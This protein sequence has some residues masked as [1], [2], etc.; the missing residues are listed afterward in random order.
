MRAQA[1]AVATLV[2]DQ[3]PFNV[4]FSLATTRAYLSHRASVMATSRK[5]LVAALLALAEGRTHPGICTGVAGAG[6]SRARLAFMFSGQGSQRRG[7]SQELC[8]NFPAFEAVFRKVCD[9]LDRWLEHPLA[10]VAHTNSAEGR[11]SHLL[12]RADY[13]QAAIFAFE[14]AIYRLL[15]SFGI[16]PDYVVGHSVGEVAAAHVAGILSLADAAM[17]VA[18]RGTFMAALPCEGA[19]ASVVA[20]EEEV[21]KMLCDVTT[22]NMGV[23]VMAAVNADNS[24][25]ISGAT[26]TIDAVMKV[27]AS[28]GRPTTRLRVSHAFHSPFMSPVLDALGQTLRV[29]GLS[30]SSGKPKIPFVST[31]TG[32]LLDDASEL[33]VDYW[34]R[35]L[36]APVRFG[37]AIRT[38]SALTGPGVTTCVEI[39][40]SPALAR[41]VPGAI[42]MSGKS[43]VNA[44]LKGFGQLWTRG[45]QPSVSNR[46]VDSSWQAIF[47]GSGAHVIDLPVYPFQ[48]RRYWLDAP[49]SVS[50]SMDGDD[51]GTDSARDTST[52]QVTPVTPSTP[53][54]HNL[55]GQGLQHLISSAAAGT[56]AAAAAVTLTWHE[57]L[58]GLPAEKRHSTL[59]CLVQDEVATVLGYQSRQDVP[60]SSWDRCLGDLGFD[61]F[62]GILLRK[63]LSKLVGQSLPVGLVLNDAASTVPALVEDLLSRM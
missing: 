61:S 26:A 33:S 59:L 36:V 9:E 35:H 1:R 6:R 32:K 5:D 22:E 10:E 45:I 56:Q 20:T 28:Q 2:N 14:V 50:T 3:D 11:D 29:R 4:A 51:S 24:V 46:G 40:P 60:V 34:T 19:M 54:E 17:L 12:D 16:R 21:T 8:A 62:M 23:A 57:Q 63:R 25:V 53:P 43:E 55:E 52:G 38:L 18:T 13:A 48:R 30:T 47:A 39:G 27:F 31:V 44:L 58:A 41:H 49:A 42:A 15:E 7:M 37:D